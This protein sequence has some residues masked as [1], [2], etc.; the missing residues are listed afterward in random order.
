[1]FGCMNVFFLTELALFTAKIILKSGENDYRTLPCCGFRY[2]QMV[3]YKM[4]VVKSS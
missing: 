3:A 4:V 1:M 2:R